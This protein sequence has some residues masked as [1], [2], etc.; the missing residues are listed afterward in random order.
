[1]TAVTAVP[2]GRVGTLERP[3]GS[4][5]SAARVDPVDRLVGVPH[6]GD[7]GVESHGR[8]RVVQPP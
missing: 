4:L 5:R 1:M 3:A 7:G 2:R 8:P 6:L